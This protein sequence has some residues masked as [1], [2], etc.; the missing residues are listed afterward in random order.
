[1]TPDPRP[2]VWNKRDPNVP[3]GAVYVGRPTK[4]GNPFSHKAGTRAK[5]RVQTRQQAIDAFIQWLNEDEQGWGLCEAAR[6]ELRGKDLVCW[7]APLPCHADIL[8]E[9]ANS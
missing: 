7:C 2:R 9:I 6:V 5:Y 4:W 3:A 8:L 1:M